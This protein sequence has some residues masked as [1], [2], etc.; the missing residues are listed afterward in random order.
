MQ[1]L[2]FRAGRMRP[3]GL[4]VQRY[5][6]LP[7]QGWEMKP[8]TKSVPSGVAPTAALLSITAAVV[9]VEL[10]IRVRQSASLFGSFTNSNFDIFVC[11]R[12]RGSSGSFLCVLGAGLGNVS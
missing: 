5:S 3:L 7:Y 1:L 4:A 9:M 6:N 12:M 2:T 11:V 8:D 10:C